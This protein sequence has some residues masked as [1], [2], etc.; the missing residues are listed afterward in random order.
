MG[1]ACQSLPLAQNIRPKKY[2]DQGDP[3]TPEEVKAHFVTYGLLTTRAWVGFKWYNTLG[4][5]LREDYS[6]CNNWVNR[7]YTFLSHLCFEL[8]SLWKYWKP[9]FSFLNVISSKMHNI[10][11]KS[12]IPHFQQPNFVLWSS[13]E[14]H[15]VF[16]QWVD[17]SLFGLGQ[18]Q[19]YHH[20][21]STIEHSCWA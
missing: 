2:T 16:N 14:R 6:N 18:T 15:L 17:F 1:V 8:F 19:D 5:H 12:Y 21:M 13:I 3:F 9:T 11:G 7:S 10:W 20:G 4:A